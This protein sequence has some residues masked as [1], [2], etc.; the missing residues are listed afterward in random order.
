M[1]TL[2]IHAGHGKTGSSYLQ[3][4]FARH[5]A[6]LEAA[7]LTYPARDSIM[8]L[9]LEGHTTSGTGGD[10][11]LRDR[12][13]SAPKDK[14]VLLSYEGFF[15]FLSRDPM[16]E[17]TRWRHWM[18]EFAFD[19]IKVLLFIRD[20]IGHVGSE[21]VQAVRYN[22]MTRTLDDYT[23]TYN[24]PQHVQRVVKALQTIAWIDL[25]VL[26]YSV[27]RKNVW[28]ETLNWLGLQNQV[29]VDRPTLVVNRSLTRGEMQI[30]RRVNRW[31]PLLAHA[32][33]FE[34][35]RMFP[36]LATGPSLVPG[37][38]AQQLV[39]EQNREAMSA[40]NS[41]IAPEQA[42]REDFKDPTAFETSFVDMLISA[43]RM[44]LAVVYFVL[45]GWALQRL[46]A[47]LQR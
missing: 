11:D 21:Y 34:G 35:L 23:S 40:V 17:M 43:L 29:P 27:V 9:A 2:W 8:K 7:G 31:A 39:I 47:R 24:R 12:I 6:V 28:E 18:K 13:A 5:R 30:L 22:A 36:G 44:G 20:P 15:G 41:M 42:Y 25:T 1:R 4:Q 3:T 46:R 26:N 14:D 32:M 45:I 16:Q 33:A 10:G 38:A 19:Q 37:S